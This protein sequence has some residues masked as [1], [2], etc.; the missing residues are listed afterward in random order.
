MVAYFR[1]HPWQRRILTLMCAMSAGLLG[2]VLLIDPVRAHLVVRSLHAHDAGERAAAIERAAAAAKSSPAVLRALER[3]LDDPDDQAFLA[4][5]SA[6]VRAGAFDKPLRDGLHIDR[7]RALLLE[8]THFETDPQH[9]ARSRA[10]MLRQVLLSGRDNVHVRRGVRAAVRDPSPTVRSMAAAMAA[11]LGM[12]DELRTLLSDPEAAVAADAAICAGVARRRTL[13]GP[14]ASLLRRDGPVETVSA[15]AYAMSI[16]ELPPDWGDICELQP[17]LRDRLLHVLSLTNPA[18]ARGAVE[19]VLAKARRDGQLPPAAAVLVAGKMDYQQ[20]APDVVRVLDEALRDGGTVPIGTLRAALDAARRLRLPVRR[21]AYELL[22]K[23]WGSGEQVS[24]V[25]GVELMSR[26]LHQ[27]DG[28]PSNRQCL[29]LL[30][31]GVEYFDPLAASAP[32]TLPAQLTSTPA[33][34]A[35]AALALW[36][37]GAPGAT[38]AVRWAADSDAALAGDIIAFGAARHDSAAALALARVLLPPIDAPPPQ[39]EYSPS[40]RA[41]GAM[42]L[43]LAS[44]EPSRRAGALAEIRAHLQ[45]PRAPRDFEALSALKCAAVALGDA[46]EAPM[47][48]ELML[49]DALPIRRVLTALALGGHK[50]AGDWLLTRVVPRGETVKLLLN[51]GLWEVVEYAWPE[52]PRVDGAAWGDLLYWQTTILQNAYMVRRNG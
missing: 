1:S 28:E 25:L 11:R 41:C 35:A 24:V 42:M 37:A 32:A 12:D 23:F 7:Y 13:D 33:A 16:T 19:S 34:S 5:A 8:T 47:L 4:V 9:A 29:E 10:L 48:M 30:Q 38:E 50:Q 20:A 45:D 39:R 36:R 14:I 21:Q 26:Q 52:L 44:Q 17:P 46:G 6:L 2:A 22:A 40:V 15:A 27:P 31:S 43:A 49:E 18:G 51:L 3:A